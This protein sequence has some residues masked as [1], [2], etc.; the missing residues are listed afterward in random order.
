MPAVIAL[1]IRYPFMKCFGLIRAI[2]TYWH[3]RREGLLDTRSIE[4][5]C[6]TQLLPERWLRRNCLE[7]KSVQRTLSRN[8]VRRAYSAAW[9]GVS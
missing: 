5:M 2:Y 6:I 7:H 4:L 8:E 3:L 9:V 1:Y